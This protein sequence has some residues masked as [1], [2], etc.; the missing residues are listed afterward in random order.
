MKP[1]LVFVT[2]FFLLGCQ[3]GAQKDN[4][5]TKKDVEFDALIKNV[6]NNITQNSKMQQKAAKS[7]DSVITKAADKITSL[8]SEVNQLKNQLNETK[9]KLDSANN[10]D[11]GK[12]FSIKGSGG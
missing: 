9:A 11:G 12:P 1:L 8:K 4:P 7:T 10:I 3:L 2:L 5:E 6:N